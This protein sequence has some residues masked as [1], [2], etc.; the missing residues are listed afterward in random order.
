MGRH[1]AAHHTRLTVHADT[2]R[3]D[4]VEEQKDYYRQRAEEYDEWWFRLGRYRLAPDASRH[5]FEDIREVD[6]ALHRFEPRGAVLEYACGTGLWTRRLAHH[7]EQVTA[8]DSSFE[9][10][11]LNQARLPGHGNVRYIHDDI[12]TWSPPVAGSTYA[13][14]PT[15]SRM[16]PMNG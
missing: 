10:I 5:W 16:S 4:I 6:A 14:S 15:G 11:R 9:M 12:F 3:M 1:P 7:A 8:V 2:R 13:S